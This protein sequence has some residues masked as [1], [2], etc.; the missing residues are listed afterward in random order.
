MEKFKWEKIKII[1]SL[2][3]LLQI[4]FLICGITFKPNSNVINTNFLSM[5]TKVQAFSNLQNFIWCFSNNLI[6]MFII[7]W[8]NYWTFGVVGT[9]WSIN[10]SLLLGSIIEYS[11][12]INSWISVS[13]VLLEFIVSIITIVSSTYFRFERFKSKRILKINSNETNNKK[14]KLDKKLRE[15]HILFMFGTIATILLISAILETIDLNLI[16]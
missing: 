5:L 2:Q 15:K 10:S 4:A 14:Y 11:L 1:F 3:I 6:V 9:I 16:K 12:I 13:F 8:I 7:F